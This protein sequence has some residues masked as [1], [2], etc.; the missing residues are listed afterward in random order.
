MTY[1]QSTRNETAE[2]DNARTENAPAGTGKV[3]TRRER[4]STGNATDA[5]ATRTASLPRASPPAPAPPLP[6]ALPAVPSRLTRTA[7]VAGPLALVAYGAI[8]LLSE[9]GVPSAGWTAGHLAMLAGVLLFVPVMLHLYRAAPARRRVPAVVALVVGLLGLLATAAQ[10]AIDL[11][12]GL[13][14][15]DR[16]AMVEIFQQVKSVPGVEPVVYGIV[17]PLFFLGLI[18]LT[19]L[20]AAPARTRV[21]TVGAMVLGAV[22]MAVN[23]DFLSLGGLCLL[24]ALAPFLLR[25]RA[26][27]LPR[28]H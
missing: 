16:P 2:T 1:P 13:M 5:Y 9:R 27:A 17:P 24:L 6:P 8:R 26:G 25:D 10:A 7:L 28:T 11:V 3:R 14:A 18:A 15:N 12:A 22:L 21:L 19:G 23:L 20:A 4:A